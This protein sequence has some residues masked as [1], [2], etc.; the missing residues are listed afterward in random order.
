MFSVTKRVLHYSIFKKTFI[1]LLQE[2]K[3]T[4]VIITE[5]IWNA[6]SCKFLY[7]ALSYLAQMDQVCWCSTSLPSYRIYCLYKML[8]DLCTGSWKQPVL[9]YLHSGNRSPA[10]LR[11]IVMFQVLLKQQNNS[12]VCRTYRSKMRIRLNKCVVLKKS[13][14]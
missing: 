1:K 6:L 9:L 11:Y 12:H 13:I 10:F 4:D 3:F 8:T 14:A 2:K 5:M 7:I